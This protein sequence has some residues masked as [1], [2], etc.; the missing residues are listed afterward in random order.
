MKRRLDSTGSC[1]STSYDSSCSGSSSCLSNSFNNF[2]NDSC[3]EDSSESRRGQPEDGRKMVKVVNFGEAHLS[4]KEAEAARLDRLL[5]AVDC[6]ES[7]TNNG[8]CLE[9]NIPDGR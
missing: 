2:I 8:A 6:R 7:E 4:D 3:E 5:E 9:V 1:L